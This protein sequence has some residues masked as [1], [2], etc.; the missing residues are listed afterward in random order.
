MP[1]LQEQ[2]LAQSRQLSPRRRYSSQREFE[3]D[4]VGACAA[5]TAC[6]RKPWP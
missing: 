5:A 2:W 6:P 3:A 4:W 1:F